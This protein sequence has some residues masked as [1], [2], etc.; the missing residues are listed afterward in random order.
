MGVDVEVLVRKSQRETCLKI[1]IVLI[2]DHPVCRGYLSVVLLICIPESP[3]V[4]WRYR[5]LIHVILVYFLRCIEISVSYVSVVLPDGEHFVGVLSF[6]DQ[7]DSSL[8]IGYFASVRSDVHT[9]EL[10][11]LM[12]IS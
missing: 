8:E 4:G 10:Q 12:R 5:G 2:N 3:N 7:G 6:T 11:S 1:R 9:S